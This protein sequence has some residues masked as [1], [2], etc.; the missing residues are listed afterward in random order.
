MIV[1]LAVG[2]GLSLAAGH[3]LEG[4]LFGVTP[5]EPWILASV[6]LLIAIA[7]LGAC[8]LPGRRAVAV[9]PI[10]VLRVG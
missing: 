1:G 8:Y 6:T 2:I 4:L 9:D 3:L 10:A 5:Q 7:A